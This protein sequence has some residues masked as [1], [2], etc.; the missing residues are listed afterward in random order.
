M[1]TGGFNFLVCVD[2]S[3]KSY[4]ALQIAIKLATN[5]KD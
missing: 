5:E 1:Q 4:K 2:G 3:L